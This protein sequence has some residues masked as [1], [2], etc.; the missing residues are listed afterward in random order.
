MDE[1]LGDFLRASRGRVRPEAVLVAGSAG[2]RVPG[3]RRIE[4]A[5]RAGVSIDYYTRLEQN[6]EQHPSAPV[7]EGLVAAL[8]LDG[9]A[10]AHLFRLAGAAPLDRPR[11][12]ERPDPRLLDLMAAWPDHPAMLLGRAFDVLAL[13]D[14]GRALLG[15]FAPSGNFVVAMFTDPRARAL[16]ADWGPAAQA[17]VDSVRL[18]LGRDDRNG[19]LLRVV[20]DLRGRSP[21]FAAMWARQ[22]ASGARLSAKTFR[23]PGAGP[24]TFDV[25]AFDVRSS[26]GQE[27]VVYHR[28][29][30][31]G[32]PGDDG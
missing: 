21:D 31:G 32:D 26:P 22:V 30:L 18:A 24:R 11:S 12:P 28:S 17:A 23:V 29:R 13:N 10:R 6:R 5:E 15:D 25:H 9:D 16:Y 8:G 7:L 3:L 20:E 2:R 4:V 27:L 19:R 14:A 1:R